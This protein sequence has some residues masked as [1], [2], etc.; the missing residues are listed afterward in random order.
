MDHRLLKRRD[1]GSIMAQ[2]RRGIYDLARVHEH[3]NLQLGCPF[4]HRLLG[5][6]ADEM[7]VIQL[8]YPNVI[9]TPPDSPKRRTGTWENWSSTTSIDFCNTDP[10]QR[11]QSR[12]ALLRNFLQ[13]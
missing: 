12:T 5:R 1:F 11:G 9:I 3:R 2:T 6:I 8:D 4:H 7:L 10:A 13:K